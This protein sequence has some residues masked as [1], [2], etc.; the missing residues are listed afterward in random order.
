MIC[1]VSDSLLDLQFAYYNFDPYTTPFFWFLSVCLVGHLKCNIV[2]F[3]LSVGICS[4]ALMCQ[5][6]KVADNKN[7][8][9]N[10][11]LSLAGQLN[12]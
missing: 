7:R 9:E 11:R 2:L 12:S 10:S 1:L 3:E 8:S 5:R 4:I 6:Q